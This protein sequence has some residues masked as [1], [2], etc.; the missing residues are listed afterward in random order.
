MRAVTAEHVDDGFDYS[1]LQELPLP[2]VVLVRITAEAVLR[3]VAAVLEEEG[4]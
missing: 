2:V 4:L 1:V 3:E